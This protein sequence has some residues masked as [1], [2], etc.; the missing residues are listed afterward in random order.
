MR[1]ETAVAGWDGHH[2]TMSS[3]GAVQS[4]WNGGNTFGSG[5]WIAANRAIYV[6]FRLTAPRVVRQLW[7]YNGTI[8]GTVHLDCGIYMANGPSTTSL[9]VSSGSTVQAGGSALQLV[10]VTDTL[11]PG[12][13]YYM[14]LVMDANSSGVF[15]CTYG[16]QNS[17]IIGMCQQASAFTLPASMTPAAIAS[18]FYP[19]FGWTEK[20]SGV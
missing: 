5:N 20:P 1:L 19:V 16:V 12:G 10:D 14:A 17:R 3:L 15:R 4:N 8:V 6:P 18:T 9:L 11:L 2:G 13:L 7:W